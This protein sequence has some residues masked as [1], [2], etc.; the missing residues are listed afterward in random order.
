M[1][2]LCLGSFWRREVVIW[3]VDPGTSQNTLTTH[4][5]EAL[6]LGIYLVSDKP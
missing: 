5:L 6:L 3:L 2:F 4:P 1:G